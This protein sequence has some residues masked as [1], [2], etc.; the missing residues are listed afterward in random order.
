MNQQ[1][2]DATLSPQVAEH[3]RELGTKDGQPHFPSQ[4]QQPPGLTAPMQPVPDHG[5]ES[6]VGHGRLEGLAGTS[7]GA[8]ADGGVSAGL[9]RKLHR[10]IQP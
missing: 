10:R 4:D 5:E 1:N 2:A 8:V 9:S 7:R 3:A 6:Y